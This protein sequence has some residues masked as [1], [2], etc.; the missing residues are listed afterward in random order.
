MI[1]FEH[2][3]QEMSLARAGKMSVSI[4]FGVAQFG[5]VVVNAPMDCFLCL[6]KWWLALQLTL[7][8]ACQGVFGGLML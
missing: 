6:T 1:S 7:R 2:C 4:S 3:Q 8:I 5:Q